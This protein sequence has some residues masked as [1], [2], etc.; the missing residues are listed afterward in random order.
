LLSACGS[1]LGIGSDIGG[2]I[3]MP[4]F[5]NGIFGHKPTT[6]VVSNYEQQPVAEKVLQNFL[7]TGPMSRHCSDLLPMYKVLAGANVDKLK[8]DTKVDS[9]TAML[10]RLCNIVNCKFDF[11]GFGFQI[12]IFLHEWIRTHFTSQPCS[13]RY[14]RSTNESR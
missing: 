2:S 5:F 3:R 1:P 7:V 6:G 9:A 12:E 10:L 4:A 8:L 13:P 14:Q 11:A